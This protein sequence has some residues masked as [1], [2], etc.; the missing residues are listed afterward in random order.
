MQECVNSVVH[1]NVCMSPRLHC[2]IIESDIMMVDIMQS[3]SS[4]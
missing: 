1:S 4:I 2:Y 3:D